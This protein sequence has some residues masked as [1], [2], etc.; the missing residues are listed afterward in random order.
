VLDGIPGA[1]LG[2]IDPCWQVFLVGVGRRPDQ[3]AGGRQL[4]H[5]PTPPMLSGMMRST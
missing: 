5:G 2:T 3:V 1:P 4:D